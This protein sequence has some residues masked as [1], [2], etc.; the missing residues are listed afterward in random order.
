MPQSTKMQSPWS[1]WHNRFHK[2]LKKNNH[3]LPIGASLLL[4][5]SGGQ[6][7]MALLKL[8]SDLQR[9]YK[10]KIHIWHG[11][12]GWHQKS[13]EFA[14]ELKAWTKQQ[15]IHFHF[16]IASKKEVYNEESARKWRYEK[17]IHTAKTISSYKS[18]GNCNYVLTGHTAS[19]KTETLIMNLARGSN[20]N[21]LGSLKYIRKLKESIQLIRPLLIF[22]REETKQICNDFDLPIWLDPSNESSDLTRNKIRKEIMPILESLHPGCTLRISSLSQKLSELYNYEKEFIKI[23]LNSLRKDNLLS[24]KE[25][26]QLSRLARETILAEWLKE[27][28]VPSVKATTIEELSYSIV[29]KIHAGTMNLPG[30]WNICWNKEFISLIDKL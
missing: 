16:D 30:G 20:L 5:V 11:D 1:E 15:N 19:D 2:S 21:G 3:P 9:I 12:H 22:T 23:V 28:G 13:N 29:T 6:D 14:L 26:C 8:I 25:F 7:S 10:W 17:L 24:R 27:E 4:S 18:L